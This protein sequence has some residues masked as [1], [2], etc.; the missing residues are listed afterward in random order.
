MTMISSETDYAI[1]I[2]DSDGVVL[3][4]YNGLALFETMSGIKSILGTLAL[5]VAHE[6]GHGIDQTTLTVAGKH[7]TNGSS[8]LKHRLTNDTRFPVS[9][10]NILRYN[11]TESDC[12]ASNVLIDYIGGKEEVNYR[13][14]QELGL[15]GIELVTTRINFDG[16]D[17]DNVPFQV[18]KGTMRDFASYYQSLWSTKE[19]S[20]SFEQ[21]WHMQLHRAVKKAKLFGVQSNDLPDHIKWVHKTGSGE[22]VKPGHLY[23]TMMD[24]GELQI[25]TRKLYVAA[26]M[27]VRHRGRDMPSREQIA[28]EFVTRNMKALASI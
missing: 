11:L 5:N 9:L 17:H 21:A 25:D 14:R 4:D 2:H 20:L 23:S 1:S 18:G 3:Y 27:T 15:V 28:D 10:M 12:V 22:D 13:I 24:A 26:A 6:N 19:Q 8:I 16:V 7:N